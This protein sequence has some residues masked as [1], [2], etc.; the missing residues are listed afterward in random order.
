MQSDRGRPLGLVTLALAATLVYAAQWEPVEQQPAGGVGYDASIAT[1]QQETDVYICVG[2]AGIDTTPRLYKSTNGG[3]A[4][5]GVLTHAGMRSVGTHP[6]H[7]EV[8]YAGG[9]DMGVYKS[10][11]GGGQWSEKQEGMGAADITTIAVANSDQSVVYAAGARYENGKIYRTTNAGDLWADVTPDFV[12]GQTLTI[13]DVAVHPQDPN[14]VLLCASGETQVSRGIYR[15]TDGG[16]SWTQTYDMADVHSVAV[17]QSTPAVAYAGAGS[18]ERYGLFLKSTDGGQHWSQTLSS[19]P[20]VTPVFS[21]A[22]HPSDPGHVYAYGCDGVWY[23]S[24]GGT[25]WEQ[26]ATGMWL[27]YGRF[28][29]LRMDSASPS[30]IYAG[31]QDAGFYRTTD[32]GDNWQQV[33]TWSPCRDVHKV[34]AEQEGGYCWVF[35]SLWVGGQGGV[36]VSTNDGGSWTTTWEH[37]PWWRTPDMVHPVA[38]TV[39]LGGSAF[40]IRVCR[41][42]D[43]GFT[44][45]MFVPVIGPADF[46]QFGVAP[47]EPKRVYASAVLNGQPRILRSD[48][49]GLEWYQPEQTQHQFSYNSVTVSHDDPNLVYFGCRDGQIAVTTDG[50]ATV[51][52]LSNGLPSPVEIR[53]LVIDPNVDGLMYAATPSGVYQ[54][55][56]QYQSAEWVWVWQLSTTGMWPNV[57]VV[58]LAVDPLCS[59]LWAASV[60]PL[61]GPHVCVS[62]DA[63]QTWEPE[64]DGLPPAADVRSLSFDS[65]RYLHAGTSVGV[66]TY[67]ERSVPIGPDATYPNWGRKLVRDPETG[68]LH[69]VYT[70]LNVV[71]YKKSTNGG[72]TW[73]DPEPIGIGKYPAIAMNGVL[74]AQGTYYP[75]VVYLAPGGSIMRA[76]RDD[77][78]GAWDQAVIFQGGPENSAGA[79]SVY[80]DV[81][82]APYPTSYVTYPVYVGNEPALSYIYFNSFTQ[83][84]V[85]QPEVVDGPREEYCYGPSVVRNPGASVHVCWIRGER[86]IYR[87]RHYLLGW[88][89]PVPISSPDPPVNE[90][91]SNPSMEAYGDHVYCVWRGPYYYGGFPGDVW[92]CDRWLSQWWEDPTDESWS[93]E[94]ESDFPV[95]GTNYATFWHEEVTA[96]NYDPWV[97]LLPFPPGPLFQTPMMS[98]YPHVDCYWPSMQTF[99]CNAVWT[100]QLS[101]TPPRYEVRF[102]T[103][104]WGSF[105]FADGGDYEPATYY[106]AELGQ[107]EPSPYCSSRGGYAKFESWDADTSGTLL[108]YRLPYLDPRRT[109]RLRAVIYHEGKES[110]SADLRC[111]SGAWHRVHVGPSVPDTLWLQVPKALYRNDACIVVEVARVKGDYVSLAQLKLFQL[112]PESYG[113]EG[114]QSTAGV[115]RTRLLNCAPNPFS[116][117]AAVSYEL[118]QAGPVALTVHDV[119]GRLV[120]RLESGYRSS[121]KHEVSWNATDDHGRRMPGGVYFLRFSAGGQASSRRVTLMR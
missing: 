81:I 89:L 17:C 45:N 34:V 51:N 121:G 13:T 68:T 117:M 79:P 61:A 48:H 46:Y 95:M 21:V 110:W 20:S 103:R 69:V 37:L 109:Y 101:A 118:A 92:K 38:D 25:T 88:S 82:A 93:F 15:S 55:K 35:D 52:S 28:S 66:F 120:R 112:E 64:V 76:I 98:R 7:P 10:T 27:K 91:A 70:G 32:G 119:S 115:P 106:A 104:Q 49:C 67:D 96:L 90:P 60:G 22:V 57:D 75:W 53:R 1:T 58:D 62:Y 8:V 102:G 72:Q 47:S 39:L 86:V 14:T 59:V 73:S 85:S 107:P 30:T 113:H 111:D 42:T 19:P 16:T 105:G 31:E 44:W 2:P 5:D 54:G 114:V 84:G 71:Y 77:A 87:E 100:E 24:D 99:K 65:D 4:W 40:D 97:R 50:G 116:R 26:K 108:T 56:Y 80:P 83:V 9:L 41:S 6:A 63:G 74:G 36:D 18:L 33:S 12:P 43:R 94:L 29:R 11:D 23:T 3:G 78:A